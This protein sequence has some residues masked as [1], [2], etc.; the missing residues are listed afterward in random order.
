MFTISEASSCRMSQPQELQ[1]LRFDAHY[2]DA[3]EEALSYLRSL[4]PELVELLHDPS[5]VGV[6]ASG[7]SMAAPV[8]VD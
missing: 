1:Q 4:S 6:F 7:A 3:A 2:S 5:G 8:A